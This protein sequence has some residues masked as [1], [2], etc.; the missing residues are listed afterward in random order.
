MERRHTIKKTAVAHDFAPEASAPE[1]EPV[2]EK[3]PEKG[4]LRAEYASAIAYYMWY[5]KRAV[6]LAGLI[7]VL[8]I[9]DAFLLK[10]KVGFTFAG[11]FDQLRLA[12]IYVMSSIGY[13]LGRV[14]NL[15]QLLWDA[16]DAMWDII[17]QFLP[18]EEFYIAREAMVKVLAKTGY[19]VIVGWLKEFFSGFRDALAANWHIGLGVSIALIASVVIRSGIMQKYGLSI[20]WSMHTV[21]WMA[22]FAL[23]FLRLINDNK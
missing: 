8:V 12:G 19:F 15:W 10:Y 20:N 6:A 13:W 3:T 2:I 9:A 22:A 23:I 14:L 21:A 17:K 1:P 7:F 18:L 16:L 11:I 5:I 4:D